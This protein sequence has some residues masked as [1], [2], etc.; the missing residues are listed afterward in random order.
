M[1]LLTRLD[2]LYGERDRQQKAVNNLHSIQQGDSESFAS[3]YPRFEREIANANA[4]GW[5][6]DSKISY[7]QKALNKKMKAQL[8]S[9]NKGNL[10]IYDTLARKC[11]NLSN[12][13]EL[14]G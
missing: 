12:R 9:A 3:F 8:V 4:E 13:M 6:D 14:L 1:L 10:A 7:L 11:E 5:P 2:L